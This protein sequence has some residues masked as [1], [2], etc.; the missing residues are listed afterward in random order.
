MFHTML[1]YHLK[2]VLSTC[3]APPETT[4]LLLSH[5]PLPRTF[6]RNSFAESR[7][8][9]YLAIHT[10]DIP[11]TGYMGLMQ[12]SYP[13]KFQYLPPLDTL[14]DY[15]RPLMHP[16]V[17]YAPV[18]VNDYMVQARAM[19]WGM[20]LSLE[21]ILTSAGVPIIPNP[22]PACSSLYAH[23]DLWREIL[24]VWLKCFLIALDDAETTPYDTIECKPGLEPAYLL[25][26]LLTA[27]IAAH[28]GVEVRSITGPQGQTYEALGD[29]CQV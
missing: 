4:R 13:V 29:V 27:V 14:H 17:V 7:A 23:V 19:H 9:L 6:L 16:R 1:A 25:E 21:R 12:A 11:A 28:P 18:V 24:P 3:P 20:D 15:L 8:T 5:L 26:R 10:G 22:A 2:D